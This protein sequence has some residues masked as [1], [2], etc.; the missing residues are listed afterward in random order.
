MRLIFIMLFLAACDASPAP[1]MMGADKVNVTVDGRDYTVWRRGTAFE[2]VRHGWAARHDQPGVE[3]T[4]LAVVTKVTGCTPHV[5]HGDS[6]EMR[7]TLTAC[8]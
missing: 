2:V 7:G 1:Q 5:E 3:A 4:M 6:G 8:K